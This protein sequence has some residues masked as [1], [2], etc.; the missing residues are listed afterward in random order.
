MPTGRSDLDVRGL[1]FDATG[2]YGNRLYLADSDPNNDDV[3]AIY[4]LLPDLTWHELS[5][6]VTTD[7]RFYGDLAISTGG[8]LAQQMYVT[9]KVSDTIMT[10]ST[11]GTHA[12]W[13]SG[14]TAIAS[15][16]AAA[17]GNAMYVSDY[18]GVYK[19]RLIADE[20]GPTII[21]REPFVPNDGIFTNDE[22][23]ASTRMVWTD[24]IS[25]TASDISVT[26][27]PWTK[28]FR[29]AFPEAARPSC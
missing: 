12:G 15:L 29:S 20:P 16:S 7:V 19:I 6:P 23:I 8:A 2:V 3:A 10:V 9:D 13:A 17:D 26:P 11:V 14:F 1:G 18:N 25:F 24:Q 22:G 5:T 28:T 27:T 21:M 4:A